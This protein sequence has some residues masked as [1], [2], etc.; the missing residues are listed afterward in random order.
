MPLLCAFA[1]YKTCEADTSLNSAFAPAV[2]ALFV[3]FV[4]SRMFATVYEC[5]ID[6]LFV[7]ALYC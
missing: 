4:V 7:C 2:A 5:T 1:T 6:T 3:S